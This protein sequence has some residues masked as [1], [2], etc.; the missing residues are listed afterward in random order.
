MARSRAAVAVGALMLA[1]AALFIPVYAH[2]GHGKIAGAS[3]DP[4]APKKVSSATA[5]AIGLTTA[6]VDFGDIEDV[7]RI[8]G[9]VRSQ[10]NATFALSPTFAGVVRSIAVQPGDRVTKGMVVAELDAPEL[11]RLTYD[12][13]RLDVEHERI[14][15]EVTRAQ[16]RVDSLEIEAPAFELNAVQAE[17]EVQRLISA[18][19]T[20]SAN[21]LAQKKADAITL[22]A[23]AG[24]RGVALVQA[25]AEVVSQGRQAEATLASGVALRGSLPR[26]GDQTEP[27]TQALIDPSRPS[28]LRFIAPIDGVVISRNATVGAGVS[29]GEAILTFGNFQSVQVEGEVP[30]G[31]I[32]RL[33]TPS[34]S[35]VRIRRGIGLNNDVIGEGVVRFLSPVIDATKRTAHLIVDIENSAGLL[36]Q[37]QFVD[38]SVVIANNT[39][40]VVVPISAIVKEGPL[41]YVYVKEG[42]GDS[43]VFLKRDVATGVR[44][45]RVVEVKEGLVPGDVIAINGAFSLSQLRGFVLGGAEPQTPEKNSGHG[46]SH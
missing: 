14:L 11:A 39:N 36:R 29:A 27:T 37:G 30:E 15:S 21:L 4:N 2:E 8:T 1:A 28:L 23:D 46:H 22:R 3:F 33:A 26:S 34:P 40:A 7:V 31:L 41:Q 10:P 38:L 19:E 18:G 25:K 17:A 9:I 13:K 35:K 45:D 5:F 43:E 20:V 6:E 44:D 16:S 24:L 12:L 42:K 32:D